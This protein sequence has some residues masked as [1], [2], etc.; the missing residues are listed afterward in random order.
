VFRPLVFEPFRQGDASST[1]YFGAPG[2]GLTMVKHLVEAHGGT[3][4]H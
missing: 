2:L 1:R 3:V 4:L